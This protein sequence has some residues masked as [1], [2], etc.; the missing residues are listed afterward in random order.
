LLVR[1]TRCPQVQGVWALYLEERDQPAG[2]GQR[3]DN[4]QRDQKPIDIDLQKEGD[5]SVSLRNGFHDSQT[6]KLPKPISVT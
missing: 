5:P 4:G 2:T 1:V 6:P 3:A